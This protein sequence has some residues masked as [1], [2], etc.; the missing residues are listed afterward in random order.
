LRLAIIGACV[1]AAFA[2]GA[3]GSSSKS[4]TSSSAPAAS[5]STTAAAPTAAK[6]QELELYNYRFDPKTIKGKPG[7]KVTLELKNEGSVEHNFSVASLHI[8]K[9][10]EA[11]KKSTV[12]LT[13]PKSGTLQF[14]CS[15]HKASHNMVGQFSLGGASASAT[16][17]STSTSTTSTSSG[18]GSGY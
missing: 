6:S 10:L 13:L 5:S 4:S 3:C 17:P 8:D 2:I 16:P 11:G 9:D 1:M 14:Y 7:Q 15:Y 12:S 18:G